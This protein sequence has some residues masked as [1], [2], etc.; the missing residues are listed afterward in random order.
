MDA[1]YSL[2]YKKY[3]NASDA[4][5]SRIAQYLSRLLAPVLHKLPMDAS[6]MDVGCGTG[7]LVN[8]LQSAGYR[9]VRGV[10]ISPQQIME[11]QRRKLPCEVVSLSYVQDL[12]RT[13][14]GSLDAIFLMDVLEHL[15][16]G[17]QIDFLRATRQ[18]LK[19]D[20][21]LVLTVPNANSNF[22]MRWRYGDWTHTASFTEDSLEFVL[23]NAGYTS[24]TFYPYEFG[25]KATFPY[26][27]SVSFWVPVVRS[28][29]RLVRR[30]EAMAELGR[31]GLSI[32]LSLNL[33][34][35]ARVGDEIV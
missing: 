5:Y 34:V 3:H 26:F 22:A 21:C 12:A 4:H 33:L 1:D 17:G 15:E 11:A 35:E 24:L 13:A 28:V 8:A 27:H 30:I 32:P 6:I 2:Q 7:L 20:G 10:D 18:L 29:F 23:R 14:P 19:P 16:V 9:S 31:A 25:G